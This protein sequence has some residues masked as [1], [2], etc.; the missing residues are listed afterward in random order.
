MKKLLVSLRYTLDA[1][2]M[3]L[4]LKEFIRYDFRKDIGTIKEFLRALN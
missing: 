3:L 4:L 2:K 1:F